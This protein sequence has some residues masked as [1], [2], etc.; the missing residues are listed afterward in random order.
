MPHHESGLLALKTT[1]PKVLDLAAAHFLEKEPD[2]CVEVVRTDE[3]RGVWLCFGSV[4]SPRTNKNVDLTAFQDELGLATLARK[5]RMPI[6]VGFAIGGYSNLQVASA[7]AASGEREWVSEFDFSWPKALRDE[8]NDPFT[9]PER[10]HQLAVELRQQNGYG[11]ISQAFG[12]DYFRVLDV[13]AGDPLF[14]RDKG[15]LGKGGFAE[16]APW[17]KSPWTNPEGNSRDG[18]QPQ[19]PA[20]WVAWRLPD[21]DSAKRRL[22]GV[23]W[24]ALEH[25]KAPMP[26]GCLTAARDGG[27]ALVVLEGEPAMAASPLLMTERFT[28]LASKVIGTELSVFRGEG[29]SASLMA[30]VGPPNLMITLTLRGGPGLSVRP[31]GE[32]LAL[33]ASTE[34]REAVQALRRPVEE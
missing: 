6:W 3:G 20:Q 26:E 19:P 24:C 27:Q 16:L 15:S 12:V 13:D 34:V 10:Y 2:H 21:D 32:P 8:A 28:Q 5:L 25:V 1:D 14:A 7:W 31:Q 33:S 29:D 17:L 30:G 11:K 4:I 23:I 9:S 22:A 18:T